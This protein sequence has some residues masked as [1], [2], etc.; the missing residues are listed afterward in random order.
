MLFGS[1]QGISLVGLPGGETLAFWRLVDAENSTLPTLSL[2]P[3]SRAL[4]AVAHM[5][6]AG[7]S[8]NQGDLL[9]WLALE[10]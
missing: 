9:Y 3:N 7:D 6:S 8:Q 5:T 1:T 2:A 4:I 10:E